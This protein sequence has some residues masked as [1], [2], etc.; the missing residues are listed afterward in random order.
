[1]DMSTTNRVVYINIKQ[2]INLKDEHIYI[3]FDKELE[4][5]FSAI[6]NVARGDRP[7]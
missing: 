5:K 6:F 7:L 4:R 2:S 1:M 3:C